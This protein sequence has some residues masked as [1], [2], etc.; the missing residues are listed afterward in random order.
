MESCCK[1]TE[2]EKGWKKFSFLKN[3]SSKSCSNENAENGNDECLMGTFE[4]EPSKV[5]D[6]EPPDGGFMV[7]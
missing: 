7:R 3:K 6:V 5:V 1:E 2:T 4:E